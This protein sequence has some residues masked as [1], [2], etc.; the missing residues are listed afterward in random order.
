MGQINMQGKQDAKERPMV[1]NLKKPSLITPIPQEKKSNKHKVHTIIPRG[2][3]E[4]KPHLACACKYMQ[5]LVSLHIVA[6]LQSS[7][8]SVLPQRAYRHPWKNQSS[9]LKK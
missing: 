5:V 9:G 4:K 3:H 7:F 8:E 1:P 2:T 6:T